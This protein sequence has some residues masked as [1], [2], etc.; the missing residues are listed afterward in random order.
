MYNKRKKV[1]NKRKKVY[2]KRKKVY[3]KR[4][5]VYPRKKQCRHYDQSN[6][7]RKNKVSKSN[8][9]LYLFSY[10]LTCILDKSQRFS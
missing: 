3:N 10:L 7:D 9:M 5:K 1:Y 8:V 6:S 4:K 2:N